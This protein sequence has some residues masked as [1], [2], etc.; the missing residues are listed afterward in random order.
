M[1]FKA[2]FE[3]KAIIYH[4]HKATSGKNPQLLAYL[5]FRNMTQTIIKDFP[6]T[7]LQKDF[8]WLLILLVNI[9]TFRYLIFKGFF[10]QA[11]KAQIWILLNLPSLL[12]KR[13]KIQRGIKVS[14]EYVISQFRKKKIAFW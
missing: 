6:N 13:R 5:Q 10:W 8:N 7:L 12:I 2:W 1:G 4:I 11:L 3:P 14:N 9:N